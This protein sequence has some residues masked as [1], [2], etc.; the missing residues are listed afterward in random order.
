MTDATAPVRDLAGRVALV[1]GA[2]RGI[3]LGVARHLLD[4]GA[5]VTITARKRPELDEAAT[6]LGADDRVL[7]VAG[8]A[9]DPAART[10][11]VDATVER[12][13][14]LDVLVNNTGI[15]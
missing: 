14:A 9:G 8:N 11:A 6:S 3:G 15:N 10:A 1:T 4:R 12:F 2:S 5:S 13:G 7:A